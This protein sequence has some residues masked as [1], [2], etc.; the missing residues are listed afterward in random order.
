MA[1]DLL[2]QGGVL[3]TDPTRPLP[4]TDEPTLADHDAPPGMNPGR[5]PL[6]D[7]D[8]PEDWQDPAADDEDVPPAD[9]PTPLSDDRR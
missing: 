9:E 3:P 2:F 5:D 4:G 6:S 1:N 7:A 8:R